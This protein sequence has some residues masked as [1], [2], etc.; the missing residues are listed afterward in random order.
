MD[1]VGGW[2]KRWTQK[3]VLIIALFLVLVANADPIMLAKRFTRDNVLRASVVAA[4][5]NIAQNNTANPTEN[6]QVRQD[7][8]KAAETLPLPLGWI[9]SP[10]DPYYTDQVPNTLVGWVLKLLGLSISVFAV[11]L[12]APFWFDMLSKV[13]NLRGAGTPPG[14]S[15]KSAPQTGQN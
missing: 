15:K 4:A 13:I 5:E 14:E 10:D 11:S 1:R 12:G 2:Y 8:L 7:L 9:P 6:V 3:A